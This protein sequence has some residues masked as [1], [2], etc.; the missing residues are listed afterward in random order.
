MQG[1]LESLYSHYRTQFVAWEAD[2]E[3]RANGRTPPVFIVGCNNIR[4]S[5]LVYDDF[6][7]RETGR[8]HPDGAREVAAGSI[9]LFSNVTDKR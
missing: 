5:Q 1:A 4:V 8:H 2:Q 3:G 9:D 7:G 6:A